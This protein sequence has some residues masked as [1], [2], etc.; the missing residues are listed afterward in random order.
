[1]TLIKG[2]I[3]A[4]IISHFK[5]TPLFW[6]SLIRSL[7]LAQACMSHHIRGDR[8]AMGPRDLR[9]TQYTADLEVGRRSQRRP[10]LAF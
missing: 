2:F 4:I 1:M 3:V 10:V 5:Q 9:G 6:R 7:C 8:L